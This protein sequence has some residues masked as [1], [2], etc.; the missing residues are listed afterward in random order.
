MET[1]SSISLAFTTKIVFRLLQSCCIITIYFLTWRI[2]KK[3]PFSDIFDQNKNNKTRGLFSF[4]ATLNLYRGTMFS[5]HVGLQTQWLSVWYFVSSVHLDSPTND[6]QLL[7]FFAVLTL[8]LLR[9]SYDRHDCRPSSPPPVYLCVN[10]GQT[11][12]RAHHT[13]HRF[14][15][16]LNSLGC[17]GVGGLMVVLFCV[18][19]SV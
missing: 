2:A 11:D 16:T 19:I 6:L 4:L 18:Q 1:F 3:V 5:E 13:R 12:P 14:V 9:I 8:Q 7:A 17:L 15:R 10:T